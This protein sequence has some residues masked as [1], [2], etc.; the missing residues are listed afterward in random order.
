MTPPIDAAMLRND[1]TGATV[2]DTGPEPR[3]DLTNTLISGN[4]TQLLNRKQGDVN[5]ALLE[6]GTI[7]RLPP[8]GA[9]RL[10]NVLAA[11]NPLSVSGTVMARSLSNVVEAWSIGASQSSMTEPAPRG[12]KAK[13]DY[14]LTT[15]RPTPT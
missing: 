12:P 1:V 13:N 7:V 15:A 3:P 2:A 14:S 11:A 5:G 10:A 9:V 4:I 8:H 6:D